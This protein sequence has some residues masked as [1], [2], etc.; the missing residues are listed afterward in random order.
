MRIRKIL[1]SF[2]MIAIVFSS[3]A[4]PSPTKV[5]AMDNDISNDI[6]V[7]KNNDGQFVGTKKINKSLQ[8]HLFQGQVYSLND[9][10]L[11]YQ[12]R[13]DTYE[14][15]QRHTSKL[16]DKDKINTIMNDSSISQEVKDDILKKS[17]QQAGNNLATV[18]LYTPVSSNTTANTVTPMNTSD[19]YYTYTDSKGRKWNMKDT[20]VYYTN[21]ESNWCDYVLGANPGTVSAGTRDFSVT[22]LGLIKYVNIFTTG[23]S[24]WQNLMTATGCKTY[25]GGTSDKL[26]F[27]ITYD[28]IN[29]W[30]FVDMTGS[31]GWATGACTEYVYKK[32][33]EWYTYLFTDSGGSSTSPTV[34]YNQTFM[35]PY[36]NDP[37]AIAVQYAGSTG[38]TDWNYKFHVGNTYYVY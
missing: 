15:V 18:D 32:T 25:Y 34:T 11:L 2:L 17:Q 12:V 8:G 26:Q 16:N 3:I 20:I 37:A 29:K 30:T 14:V 19:R 36:F 9:G 38:Y 4:N 27:N 21:L 6:S 1:S 31:G 7:V 10:T 13:P 23:L 22:M 5:F 33:I 28:V 24:I 35:S